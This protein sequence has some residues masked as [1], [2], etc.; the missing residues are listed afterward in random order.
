MNT[1]FLNYYK[2][3]LTK[4]SFDKDLLIKEYQKALRS[5]QQ[6]EIE[7]LNQWLDAS[8]YLREPT[9]DT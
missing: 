6:D 2:I 8:G 3:I 9:Q 4:M 5:I 1:S 7:D